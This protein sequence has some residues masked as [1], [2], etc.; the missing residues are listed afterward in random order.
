MLVQYTYGLSNNKIIH[1]I[2]YFLEK[3]LSNIYIELTTFCLRI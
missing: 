3:N 1:H 2:I